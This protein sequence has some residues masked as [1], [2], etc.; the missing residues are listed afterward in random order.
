[1]HSG[2]SG[3]PAVY[4]QILRGDRRLKTHPANKNAQQLS[5]TIDELFKLANLEAKGERLEK[6]MVSFQ[7]LVAELREEFGP[8]LAAK[9]IELASESEPGTEFFPGHEAY[10]RRIFH[11][12]A[13]NAVKYTNQGRI[14]IAVKRTN[15]N[16]VVSVTDSGLG[17]PSED[18]NRVFERFYRVDKDRSR[19][20]GGTGIGLALVKHL[21]QIQ[22]GQ[23][24]AESSLGR[25]STFYFS[26]P[27]DDCAKR[28]A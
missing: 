5:Q 17:I 9:G 6:Q 15:E 11:S 21:V 3:E 14:K 18:L 24:W 12:L 22:G 4:G 28:L 1:L 10:L 13:D 19:K 27:A 25:G 7:S 8:R 20:S 2:L 26:L 16:V 23:V